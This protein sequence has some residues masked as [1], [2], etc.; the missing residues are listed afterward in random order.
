MALGLLLR[1]F[2]DARGPFLAPG[3]VLGRLFGHFWRLCGA[4]GSS[5]GE[6]WEHLGRPWA[7]KVHLEGSGDRFLTFSGG[8]SMD[9][10]GIFDY[11]FSDFVA[12]FG[13]VCSGRVRETREGTGTGKGK[14]A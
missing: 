12:A 13:E 1:P 6:L 3:G 2:L 10:G 9:F 5:S 8:F 7:A 4:L 14:A 11:F